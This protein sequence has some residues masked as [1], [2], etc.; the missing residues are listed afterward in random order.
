LHAALLG[1][2]FHRPLAA[3]AG[4]NLRLD[5]CQRAAKLLVGG[6]RF[7]S[8]ARY[9]APRHGNARVAQDLLGLKFVGFHRSS[10]PQRV[11]VIGGL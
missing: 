1:I 2:R 11:R 3:A 9:N 7:R 4:M 8:R 5:D 10:L 6:R